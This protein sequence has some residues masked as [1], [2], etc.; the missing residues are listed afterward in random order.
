MVTPRPNR[1]SWYCLQRKQRR[2]HFINNEH[3]RKFIIHCEYDEYLDTPKNEFNNKGTPG[4]TQTYI[5]VWG[6]DSSHD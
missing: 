1:T 2:A 6:N 3:Q 4:H 5:V